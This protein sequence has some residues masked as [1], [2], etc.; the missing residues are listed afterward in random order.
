MLNDR[1]HEVP[2][3]TPVEWPA[4]VR[5]PETLTEQIQRLVRVQMSQFAEEQGLETFEEADDF[6]ID[7]EEGAPFSPYELTEMQEERTL[8]RDASDL[9]AR[10]RRREDGRTQREVEQ[11]RVADRES[12]SEVRPDR[13]SSQSGQSAVGERAGGTQEG[14]ESGGAAA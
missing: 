11:P 7:D 6:D 8:A 10:N 12:V 13:V 9:E 14:R 3:P 5:R 2:D 4:G 1:G